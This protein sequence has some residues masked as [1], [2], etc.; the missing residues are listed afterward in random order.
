M[1]DDYNCLKCE[2]TF[3]YQK[4]YGETFPEHPVCPHCNE[5]NTKRIYL[6]KHAMVP[7][8]MRSVNARK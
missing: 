7:D 1:T 5:N 4:P 6:N 2:I 3:E 8:H